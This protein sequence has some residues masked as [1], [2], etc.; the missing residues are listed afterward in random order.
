MNY[1][2]KMTGCDCLIDVSRI[3]IS[4]VKSMKEIIRDKIKKKSTYITIIIE[5]DKF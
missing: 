3:I 2:L 1:V 4:S 5:N